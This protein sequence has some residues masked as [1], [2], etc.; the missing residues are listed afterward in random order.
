M[1]KLT[2]T[3][4]SAE[5]SRA[6]APALGSSV[7][8]RSSTFVFPDSLIESLKQGIRRQLRGSETPSRG[9]FA[10][11]EFGIVCSEAE[12]IHTSSEHVDKKHVILGDILRS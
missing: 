5:P 8:S 4:D 1:H 12:D 7:L 2:P 11:T 10:G 6:E 9:D 3:Y